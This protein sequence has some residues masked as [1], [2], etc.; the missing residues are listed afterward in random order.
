[1]IENYINKL[2]CKDNLELLKELPDNSVDLIYGDILYGTGRDFVDYVDLKC[3]KNIIESFYIPRLIE[4]KRV[5]KDTGSVYLQMDTRINHWM[6]IMMDM[7]FG[8]NNFRN[9]I[10]WCYNTQGKTSKIWN[11][12]H[13]VILFYTKS[14]NYNFYPEKIKESISYSTYDRFKKEI[15]KTG[16]YS[17][18]KKGKLY[19]YEVSDGCLPKD[20]FE[21]TALNSSTSER[22]DYQTQKPEALLE[23]LILACSN[24]NDIVLD[25][26]LGSGTTIVVSEKLNRKWIGVDINP[27][28]IEITNQRL[29]K[30]NNNNNYF[31][32][33]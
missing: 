25:C 15:D 8:Y 14:K 21:I 4:M 32:F 20:W 7:V 9:E 30:L 27:K 23:R 3:D 10:V 19:S 2:F 18:F 29:K 5:L 16:K 24:E 1:M 33:K 22:V 6:R 11:Q 31:N 12:K 28:S 13:D 17:I 26:F